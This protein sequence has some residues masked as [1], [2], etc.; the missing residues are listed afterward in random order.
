[1]ADTRYLSCL[2][3]CANVFKKYAL[4]LNNSPIRFACSPLYKPHFRQTGT[5]CTVAFFVSEIK[6]TPYLNCLRHFETENEVRT[7]NSAYM[8]NIKTQYSSHKA[9]SSEDRNWGEV[10]CFKYYVLRRGKY[11]LMFIWAFL[12]YSTKIYLHTAS[13]NQLFR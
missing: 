2:W 7:T 1:M 5:L 8:I 3:R 11:R 4:R 13:L 12:K 10:I 9:F 6:D